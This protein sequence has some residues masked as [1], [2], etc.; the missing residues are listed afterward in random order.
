[1]TNIKIFFEAN[2]KLKDQ[3]HLHLIK[4]NLKT[5]TLKTLTHIKTLFLC[6]YIV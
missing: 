4:F 3:I 1:M 5:A 6:I 2:A